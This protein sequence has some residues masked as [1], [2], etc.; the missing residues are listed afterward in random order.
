MSAEADILDRLKASG[1]TVA[2]AFQPD[3]DDLAPEGTA[4]LVLIA[5]DPLRFWEVFS[6]SPE[7]ADGAPDPMDRWS[8]RVIDSIATA[9][10]THLDARALFPFGGPPWQPFLR[11]AARGEGAI[12]SPVA[13]QVSPS[14][15][16]WMSYRGALALGDVL[17]LPAVSMENPCLGC[18]APCLDACPVSAFA[19]GAYDVARCVA[20][21]AAEKGK[22]CR[23][24]CLVRL[25]CPVGTPPSLAQRSFHMAAFLTAQG[26]RSSQSQS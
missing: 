25:A 14:R 12:S 7:K 5:P 3:E 6:A 8:R 10:P 24:G 16:L 13:M 19:G 11:W 22:P 17:D 2:G 15:G 4:M 9:L 21:V 20:H 18:P 23:E 26:V 1:L